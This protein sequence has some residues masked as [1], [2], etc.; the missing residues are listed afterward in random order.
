MLVVVIVAICL[1]VVSIAI[2]AFSFGYSMANWQ[3]SS[4]YVRDEVTK[5]LTEELHWRLQLTK[6]TIETTSEATDTTVATM[7]R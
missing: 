4:T 7:D 6:D 1:S 2:S 3:F 5:R